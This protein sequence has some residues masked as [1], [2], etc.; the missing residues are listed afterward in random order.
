[1]VKSTLQAPRSTLKRVDAA[2][3]IPATEPYE[4]SRISRANPRTSS[5]RDSSVMYSIPGFADRMRAKS[6]QPSSRT[7]WSSISE[8]STGTSLPAYV[9]QKLSAAERYSPE[10][11]ANRY[12]LSMKC[13]RQNA[14][15][16]AGSPR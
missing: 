6:R 5:R 4:P 9:H 12:A 14:A 15:S 11:A 3:R 2:S 10:V 8:R 13:V 1:M 16:N 7:V